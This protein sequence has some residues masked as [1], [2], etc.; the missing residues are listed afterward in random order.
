M[1]IADKKKI[2]KSIVENLHKN[3]V[4]SCQLMLS[5]HHQGEDSI[6]SVRNYSVFLI[7]NIKN[8][9]IPI[10]SLVD[11]LS[12][13]FMTSIVRDPLLI[14]LFNKIT[15]ENY[16]H[17]KEDLLYILDHILSAINK[18]KLSKYIL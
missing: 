3:D 8:Y 9:A 1:T 7:D 16:L 15:S 4:A 18:K 6:K 2:I 5:S 14:Y 13:L 10:K 11:L 12:K 17:N